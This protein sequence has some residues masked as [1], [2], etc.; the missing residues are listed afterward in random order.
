MFIHKN[1]EKI[2]LLDLVVYLC[3]YFI[4]FYDIFTWL[5]FLCDMNMYMANAG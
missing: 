4:E 5:G 3:L 2:I 1:K